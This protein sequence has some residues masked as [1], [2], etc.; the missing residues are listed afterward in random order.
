MPTPR[1]LSEMATVEI[2]R[3]GLVE[4]M[5]YDTG[6]LARI[7]AEWAAIVLIVVATAAVIFLVALGAYSLTQV[8]P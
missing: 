4:Q 7:V 3:P 5:R 8:S 2:P 6:F 1:P